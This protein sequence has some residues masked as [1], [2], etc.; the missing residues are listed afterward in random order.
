MIYTISFAL[1][2]VHRFVAESR[3][4]GFGGGAPLATGFPVTL[5]PATGMPVSVNNRNNRKKVTKSKQQ[6]TFR[7]RQKFPETWLWSEEE[8][9]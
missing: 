3:R 2:I 1:Y 4:M 7:V 8:T 6:Q 9:E 5:P